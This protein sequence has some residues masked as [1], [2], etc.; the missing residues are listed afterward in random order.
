MSITAR[1]GCLLLEA[2]ACL[3]FVALGL[4]MFPTVVIR[5]S[6]AD[7]G[8]AAD[9]FLGPVHADVV[10]TVAWSVTAAARRLPGMSCLVEA[11][12]AQR[13]LRRRHVACDVRLGVHADRA[14]GTLPFA[15]AWL[16]CQGQVVVGQVDD[17]GKFA[18]LTA[19]SP[20]D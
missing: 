16:E 6:L 20:D 7:P 15:H 10:S 3:A 11:L 14:Q 8:A 13:M 2:V 4:R 18:V 17:L 19:R 1:E 9:L 5:R 12:A